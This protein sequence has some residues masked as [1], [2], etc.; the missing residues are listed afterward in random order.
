M[1][2]VR[3]TNCDLIIL[4]PWPRDSWHSVLQPLLIVSI[5]K[6]LM[7]KSTTTPH[8][9]WP[10]DKLEARLASP[11]LQLKKT[12]KPTPKYSINRCGTGRHDRGSLR[13]LVVGT[14]EP[15]RAIFPDKVVASRLRCHREPHSH[16]SLKKGNESDAEPLQLHHRA[17]PHRCPPLARQAH[18]PVQDFKPPQKVCEDQDSPILRRSSQ[19]VSEAAWLCRQY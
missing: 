6:L 4:N 19:T 13:S 10:R 11:S 17:W 3:V 9:T 1:M 2:H 7:G 18:G 14:C 5:K 16:R 8:A 15:H 12:L